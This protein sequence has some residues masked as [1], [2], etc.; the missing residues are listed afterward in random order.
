MD[1]NII[2]I[3]IEN[4]HLLGYL[5]DNLGKIFN[6]PI[7][8][9]DKTDTGT[10]FFNAARGQ[11]NANRILDFLARKINIIPGHIYLGILD[12]DL[13]VPSLNFVFGLASCQPRICL[14]STARLNP[15]FY[16]EQINQYNEE[17]FH[18]RIVTEAVHEIG[19][20]LG[21]GHCQNSSCV[22]YFLN[23]LQDTDNKGVNFC[24]LCKKELNRAIRLT[25]TT[26]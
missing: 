14:I 12:Q 16:R 2:P 10:Q 1:I 22:M 24:K 9:R 11:H 25:T 26:G 8:I 17:N 19:Y 18:R 4:K 5:V 3:N 6:F 23:T 7:K 20:A 13:Y 21:L 15:A